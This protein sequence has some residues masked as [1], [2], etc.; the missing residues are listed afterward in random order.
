MNTV[1]WVA[2]LA[3][4]IVFSTGLVLNV[5]SRRINEQYANDHEVIAAIMVKDTARDARIESNARQIAALLE[6]TKNEQASITELKALLQ[7]HLGM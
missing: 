2:I 3:S 5:D 1:S 6:I 4:V 7:K